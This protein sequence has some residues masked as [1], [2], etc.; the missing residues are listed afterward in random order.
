MKGLKMSKMDINWQMLG[1]KKASGITNITTKKG[2]IVSNGVRIASVA[3]PQIPSMP[4]IRDVKVETKKEA[5]MEPIKEVMEMTDSNYVESEV[6][7]TT[8]TAKVHNSKSV[9]QKRGKVL[10]SGMELLELDFLLMTVE[11]TNGSDSN[12]VNMRRMCFT[13]ILRREQIQEIDSNALA[14]YSINPDSLYGKAIQCQAMME[15]AARTAN[16]QR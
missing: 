14:V 15:L 13:E 16:S 10:S 7:E 9:G 5:I 6:I 11:N 1:K 3:I 4:G 8:D 12:D 2:P